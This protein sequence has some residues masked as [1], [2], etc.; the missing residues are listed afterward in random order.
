MAGNATFLRLPKLL[1]AL[2]ALPADR[3]VRPEVGGLAGWLAGWLAE[4]S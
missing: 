4:A 2:E 1:D 3:E